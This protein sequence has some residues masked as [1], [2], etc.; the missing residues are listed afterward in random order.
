[1]NCPQCQSTSYRKNGRRN[2]RQ[3]YLCKNC[4]R[5]FLE[6]A[7]FVLSTTEIPAPE[8]ATDLEWESPKE[9]I[10]VTESIDSVNL[11][12]DVE[13]EQKILS[14]SETVVSVLLLDAEN[15]KIDLN[16]ENFLL[17][18]AQSPQLI[19]IAFANWRNTSLAKQDAD[20]Y[21]RG[22]QLIHV[23]NGKNSADAK[24]I[25]FG[26][27]I[28]KPYPQVKEVFI[29]SSDGL[30]MHLCHQLQNHGI[31]VYWVRRKD[32]K[33]IVENRNTGET[34]H[35]LISLS[36]EIPPLDM[37]MN[38]LESLIQSERESIDERISKIAAL[39]TLFQAR[40]NIVKQETETITTKSDNHH[41]SPTAV[42][43]N[44]SET[45]NNITDSLNGTQNG[46]ATNGNKQEPIDS[47]EKLEEALLQL[48][49]KMKSQSTEEDIS[50]NTLSKEFMLIYGKP[51][52]SVIKEL[53]LGSTLSKF[54][55][56]CSCFRV[57]QKGNK[58]KIELI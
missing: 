29:C 31:L 30:L 57:Q 46:A 7:S 38:Q 15:L 4:G 9:D 39:S 11:P 27:S 21:D 28:F 26:A 24:M 34:K 1:M 36:T 25:A 37:L 13:I 54:L 2:G 32:E 12:S 10:P 14:A 18:L 53:G 55:K 35:Y 49:K 17:S 44:S 43:L 50:P 3:N 42:I 6:T 20:L 56:S 48:I 47:K 8:V 22:Y 33:L 41:N 51:P 58:F 23:P 16:A 19:K 45:A 5:Q 52:R 40:S